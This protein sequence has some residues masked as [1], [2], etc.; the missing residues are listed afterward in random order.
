M[1]TLGPVDGEPVFPNP[2]MATDPMAE[3]LDAF[4][5]EV[6]VPDAVVQIGARALYESVATVLGHGGTRQD[7]SRFGA[8]AVQHPQLEVRER[9]EYWIHPSAED[10]QYFPTNIVILG[11]NDL[12]D[13]MRRFDGRYWGGIAKQ[14]HEGRRRRHWRDTKA[15]SDLTE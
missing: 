9:G 8:I 4:V 10:R 7:M 5:A 1:A 12:D 14:R 3:C 15:P 13:M 11:G 6:A 2:G